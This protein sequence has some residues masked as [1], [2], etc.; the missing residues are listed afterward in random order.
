M[1]IKD[2]V[3]SA[4]LPASRVETE[5]ISSMTVTRENV[6]SSGTQTGLR[7]LGTSSVPA[8][9]ILNCLP[10]CLVITLGFYC[11][12]LKYIFLRQSLII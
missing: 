6:L 7:N 3:L 4:S 1:Y 9:Q 11:S 8:F 12:L 2:K 10:L 5:G